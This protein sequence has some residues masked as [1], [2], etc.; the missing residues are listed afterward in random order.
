MVPRG[1]NSKFKIWEK[2]RIQLQDHF[3]THGPTKI[4]V[5]AFTLWSLIRDS[6]DPRHEGL[7]GSGE[8]VEEKVKTEEKFDSQ[9]NLV[10][11]T[12]PPPPTPPPIRFYEEVAPDRKY[13]ELDPQNE[14]DLEKEAARYHDPDDPHFFIAREQQPEILK[15]EDCSPWQKA[16]S[17]ILQP[18]LPAYKSLAVQM[19]EMQGKLAKM[20][21]REE[22]EIWN[23]NR[24][25]GGAHNPLRNPFVAP[26]TASLGPKI[27]K[28][29][30]L[31]TSLQQAYLQGED[32]S[33]FMAFPII[34]RPD[35]QGGMIRD[36]APILFKN[37]K[38][39]KAACAQYGPIYPHYA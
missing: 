12:A 11:P 25:A 35:G 2:V 26:A 37:L 30:R 8:K 10:V 16:E 14:E 36:H 33:G 32:L 19:R 39:L 9:P 29:P 4:P 18:P 28:Q 38:E 15:A 5:D 27:W 21:A 6:L 17:K 13:K 23:K 34:E 7:R 20:Q 31:Q 3:D 24:L 22:G 1:G